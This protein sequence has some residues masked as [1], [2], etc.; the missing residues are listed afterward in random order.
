MLTAPI[1]SSPRAREF[2]FLKLRSRHE[3]RATAFDVGALV[4]T[5]VYS[6]TTFMLHTAALLWGAGV[7]DAAGALLIRCA[8]RFR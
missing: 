6:Y 1:I 5:I 8:E 4:L 3:T 7:G 2:A